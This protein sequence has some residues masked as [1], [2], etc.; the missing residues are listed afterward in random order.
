MATERKHLLTEHRDFDAVLRS[1]SRFGDYS[2]WMPGKVKA[3]STAAKERSRAAQTFM[4][5]P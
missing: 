3:S 4:S 2:S 5:A 1:L